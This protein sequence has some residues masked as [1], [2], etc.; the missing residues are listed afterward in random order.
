[1]PSGNSSS[2]KPRT[3]GIVVFPGF[4]GLDV[5]GPLAFITMLSTSYPINLTIIARTLDPYGTRSIVDQNTDPS[6]LTFLR[7]RA[8]PS[9][10]E[11]LLS[12]CTGASLL[13]KAGNLNG[14]RATTNKFSYSWVT[15]ITSNVTWVPVA[16]W[17]E[18]E[19]MDLIVYWLSKLYC[20]SLAERYAN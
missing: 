6:L 2:S 12:V 7:E 16:R 5:F 18:D 19:R 20:A 11:Y 13:A 3:V 1:M 17:V 8:N 9:K 4:A 14:R 15:S 10:L